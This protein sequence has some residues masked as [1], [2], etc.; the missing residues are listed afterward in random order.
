VA[1]SD[2]RRRRVRRIAGLRAQGL[3][4]PQI[5]KRLGIAP[6]TVRDYERDPFRQKARRRQKRWAVEGVSMPA[7][8]T[9]IAGVKGRW[10]KGAPHKGVG[11]AHNLARGRQLR[12]VIGSRVRRG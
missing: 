10:A 5:G 7:G 3:N 2:L 9:P 11:K 8:G 4:S 12:A 1:S 6:S